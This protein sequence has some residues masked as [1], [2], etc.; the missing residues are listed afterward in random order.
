MSNK[1]KESNQKI[2]IIVIFASAIAALAGLL[3]GFDTGIISGALEFI[4][5]SFQ[6]TT[7]GK[8]TVV[9]MVLV[10][11]VIGALIN[12]MLAD[13][14]GRKRMVVLASLL[15]IVGSVASALSPSELFL[16]I[17]RFVL[18]LAIGGA[19][20]SAP[21]YIAEVS[22][23]RI[24]GSLVTLFQLAITIGI[25][26]AYFVDLAF[27]A[28]GNWR[29][30]L[31]SSFIPAVVLL[32]GMFGLPDS[33]RWLI[34]R[35]RLEDA[36]KILNKIYE[37]DTTQVS[38]EIEDIQSVIA[39]ES[40][41]SFA[42][43]FKPPASFALIIAV[44]LFIIQQFVGINTVIYYAPIIFKDAGM[45]SSKAA[46]WATVS[47][48]VV[49]VLATFI[50]IWLID[51]VGRKPLMYAGLIGMIL[52]LTGMGIAYKLIGSTSSSEIGTITVIAVWI[53]I[54]CFAF[55]FGPIPWLM[56]T[57]IFP[58]QLRGRAVSIATMTSWGCN[59]IVSFTFLSLL[60]AIG[61]SY[62]FWLY[63]LVGILGLFF[64]WRLVPETKGLSLEAIEEA[65]KEKFHV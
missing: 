65:K 29:F 56:M 33:P 36:K 38:T 23:A 18:G 58:L 49:N 3:A 27:T 12:G 50:A 2:N 32:I 46:I 7:I 34:K 19:S 6:L 16:E 63:A 21:L 24:R 1:N 13:K 40:E 22:P 54:A 10:G 4:A 37:G 9:S 51:K 14:L 48:G 15:Y 61:T 30:M 59:L 57:E 25:L 60:N 62:T 39:T 17:S 47:V 11:G 52:S 64:V 28:S 31:G 5:K 8:E 44:G 26:A 55:S 53:Y 43:L 45:E 42:A 41:G 20:A 35:G